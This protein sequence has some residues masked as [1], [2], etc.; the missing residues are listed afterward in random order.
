[1]LFDIVDAGPNAAGNKH[2]IVIS[3]PSTNQ[4]ILRKSMYEPLLLGP[5]TESEAWGYT[6]QKTLKVKGT[7]FCLQAVG[8]GKPAKLSVVCNLPGSNWEIVSGVSKMYLST[9]LEDGTTVCLDA[10]SSNHIVTNT[11]KC[12]SR[13][14]MCDPGCQWFKIADISP[15]SPR[16]ILQI[17]LASSTWD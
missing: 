16:H 8:L 1:M 15:Y 13:D 17:S 4:C 2:H 9:R 7:Y 3:H 10:D 5:C 6:P 12:S 14:D 11:C